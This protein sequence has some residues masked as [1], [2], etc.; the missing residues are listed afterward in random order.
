MS[1]RHPGQSTA[2][3]TTAWAGTLA[4]ALFAASIHAASA[5]APAGIPS[6]VA[7]G[8]EPELVQ[9]G[10]TVIEGP[11]GAADGTIYFSDR[12]PDRTYHVDAAGK[13]SVFRENTG[14]AN[15]LAFMRNGDMVAAEGDGKQISKVNRDGTA[16]TLADGFDGKPFI[17][18]NDLIADDKG[19]IYFTD[20]GA[21]PVVPGRPTNVYYLPPGAGQPILIDDQNP[22][23]NGLTLTL[24]GK[25]LLVDDTLGNTV[26]AFDVQPD[27]AAKNKRPF[28]ELQ[29][30]PA[31]KDSVADGMA[32]DRDGRIYVTTL[33]GVQVFDPA[34][35]YLGTIKVPRQPA[36]L[37][38]GGPDKRTLYLTARQ[39]L[40]RIQM[41]AQG[42]DR[43]GK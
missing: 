21:R 43:L 2:A 35:K 5:Q 1:S 28:L 39:G 19:G 36:N 13:V 24:D 30:I 20:P 4:A 9:E 15:G 29:G 12:K 18:P 27:G 33:T 11:V 17:T 6:V 8:V 37:A 34:G 41:L 38:F 16:T 3:I 40:Y 32:I 42:P 7:P 23:P 10:F 26:Y 22:R 14:A 31:G 25:M